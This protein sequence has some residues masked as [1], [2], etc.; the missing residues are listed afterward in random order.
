MKDN[1]L[2]F[3]DLGITLPPQVPK[4]TPGMLISK[5]DAPRLIREKIKAED[6]AAY[7]GKLVAKYLPSA[8][9]MSWI[10][11]RIREFNNA[12]SSAATKFYMRASGVEYPEHLKNFGVEYG[13]EVSDYI[14]NNC[15][16]APLRAVYSIVRTEA[17]VRYET[18][19]DY[20]YRL[21][22]GTYDEKLNFFARLLG[23]EYGKI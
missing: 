7:E 20:L 16:P 3:S 4:Y 6:L 21:D 10:V 14:R 1:N 11:C 17:N 12:G 19:A 22:L 23:V 8:G 15:M 9:N 18:R 13:N 2:N 5:E